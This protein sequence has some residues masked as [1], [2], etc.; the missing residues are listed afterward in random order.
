MLKGW[1][2]GIGLLGSG[3]QEEGCAERVKGRWVT[4]VPSQGWI[5]IA[6]RALLDPV[7][8]HCYRRGLYGAPVGVSVEA[9]EEPAP[10]AGLPRPYPRSSRPPP[11]RDTVSPGPHS[12]HPHPRSTQ[13]PSEKK[14][15]L[16][17]SKTD[18]KPVMSP[19]C[20]SNTWKCF[21]E[22]LSCWIMLPAT[23]CS[24]SNAPLMCISRAQWKLNMIQHYSAHARCIHSCR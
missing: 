20:K 5:M 2:C 1:G 22:F 21:C 15:L 18:T 17:M 6:C 16:I 8:P 23:I 9:R 3:W 10:P 7:N 19:F 12:L 13:Q 4:G 14:P 11:G 24:A